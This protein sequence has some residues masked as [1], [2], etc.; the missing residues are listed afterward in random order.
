MVSQHHWCRA[1]TVGVLTAAVVGGLLVTTAPAA[2]ESARLVRGQSAIVVRD[3]AALM[4]GDNP[5]AS[6]PRGTRVTVANIAST[7]IGV[8]LN[9][10]GARASG[11]MYP[12]DLGPDLE[13]PMRPPT[14]PPATAAATG[15]PAEPTCAPLQPGDLRALIETYVPDAAGW[16]VAVD[17]RQILDHPAVRRHYL[18]RMKRALAPQQGPNFILNALGINPFRDVSAILITGSRFANTPERRDLTL[19]LVGR[20]EPR[21]FDAWMEDREK[22]HVAQRFHA[23]PGTAGVYFSVGD[24]R[25]PGGQRC[26]LA[27]LGPKVLIYGESEHFVRHVVLCEARS[28][29]SPGAAKVRRTLGQ[30]DDKHCL[31]AALDGASLQ[32]PPNTAPAAPGLERLSGGITL[33]DRLRIELTAQLQNPAAAELWEAALRRGLLT[34]RGTLLRVDKGADALSNLATAGVMLMDAVTIARSEATVRIFTEDDAERLATAGP[35]TA[36]PVPIE[37]RR[38]YERLLQST[39]YIQC[40]RAIGTGTLID[41]T[42]RLVLTCEHVVH[43]GREARVLFPVFVDGKL[44]SES[45]YYTDLVRNGKSLRAK[46]HARDSKRDLAVLQLESVPPDQ[47]PLTLSRVSGKPAQNVHSVGNPNVGALWV[48]THGTVRQVAF[49]QVVEVGTNTIH[50]ARMVLTDSPTNPG[51]S[52]GPLVNDQLELLGVLHGI[53][54]DVRGTSL[55]VDVSEV[56]TFLGEQGIHLGR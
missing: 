24:P 23:G 25:V 44:V 34:G 4:S 45:A 7:W 11:W 5:V 55:F 6:L 12:A 1:M 39:V 21:Q 22:Y 50:A 35:E 8:W 51:D 29:D 48:Y 16:V 41:R 32:S 20:F 31:W 49:R 9:Q 53:Q 18:E 33:E 30:C 19:I 36:G 2:D 37:S 56:T 17:V 13:S 47:P 54:R 14:P 43:D 26:W 38:L 42:Q 40:G 28:K 3:G 46:I 52:G 27:R 10:D 15:S